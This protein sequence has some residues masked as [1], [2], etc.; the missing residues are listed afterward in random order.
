MPAPPIA[1]PAPFT[2]PSPNQ[3]IKIPFKRT[4]KVKG[5]TG[6]ASLQLLSGKKVLAK[7]S[8][9]FAK[10]CKLNVTF[11]IKAAD[12]KKLTVVVSFHGKKKTFRV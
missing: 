12:M 11:S 1:R 9:K 4:Y 5:C 7:K 2:G 8:V 3:L 6:K 10:G